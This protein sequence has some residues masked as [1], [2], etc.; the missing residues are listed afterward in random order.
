MP[1]ILFG[2]ARI[3]SSRFKCNYLKNKKPFLNFL[4]SWWNL[5]QM[6]NLFRYKMIVIGNVFLRLQTVKNLVRPL[7]KKRCFRTSLSRQTLAKSGWEIFSHIFWS[8]WREMIWKISPLLK[9]EILGVFRNTLTADENYPFRD[10]GV[11]TS[12]F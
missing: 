11:C 6:L 5:R 3:C 12:L 7:S 9:F 1:S 4:F 10:S 8:F 2:N